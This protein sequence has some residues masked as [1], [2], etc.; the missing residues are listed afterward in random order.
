M[1]HIHNIVLICRHF[2]PAVSGGARRPYLLAQ[3]LIRR[4]HRVVVIAPQECTGIDVI[5]VPH[6][7]PEPSSLP[8]RQ[9]GLRDLLREWLLLPDPDIRW[10]LRAASARLPF[11]PDWV[12]S[13]SPPE[14]A[15]VAGWLLARRHAARWLAD[16]R[17]HWLAAPL[18][19][20]RRRSA[21]RRQI[22]TWLA[23]LLLRQADAGIATTMAIRDEMQTLGLAAPISVLGPF[24]AAPEGRIV[25][26]GS[27]PKLVH[28]GSF[29]LSDPERLIGP[30]L[31][32]MEHPANS[33]WRLVLV[34]R[35]TAQEQAEV[36]ASPAAD[37]IEQTGPVDLPTARAFQA[38][39][40]ALLLVTGPDTPHIPGKLAEYQAAGKPLAVIGGGS[41]LAEA[42]LSKSAGSVAVPATL[43]E[44][45]PATPD[46][47]LNPTGAVEL[48]LDLLEN[49]G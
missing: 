48:L 32:A 28:T 43:A 45:P 26:S 30:V 22:E 8:P 9:P 49:R 10:A 38:G 20:V 27:G 3:E 19:P 21:W 41:W 42:G 16:C 37:R 14:S 4:G 2:P 34:G 47:T 25:P 15:H 36:A 11:E 17:D 23:R 44:A 1:T 13:S 35:L 33:K 7:H 29:T 39:A 5:P 40:D 46:S 31:R 12:I 24:A 18:L 6:S